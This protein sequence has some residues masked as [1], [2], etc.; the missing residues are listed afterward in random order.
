[1]RKHLLDMVTEMFG[2]QWLWWGGPTI[3]VVAYLY[4]WLRHAAW[5]PWRLRDWVTFQPELHWAGTQRII[6]WSL[7]LPLLFSLSVLYWSL[8]FVLFLVW[9]LLVLGFDLYGDR[10]ESKEGHPNSD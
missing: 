4:Y 1:M 3:F 2:S 5:P 10:R 7:D 6:E 9:I 8:L